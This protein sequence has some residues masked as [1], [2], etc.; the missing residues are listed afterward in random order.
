MISNYWVYVEIIGIRID[1]EDRFIFY[2]GY[3][4]K[5]IRNTADGGDN[6]MHFFNGISAHG[7]WL[8]INCFYIIRCI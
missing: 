3:G 8:I 4:I 5:L 1:D 6:P 7:Y 2:C